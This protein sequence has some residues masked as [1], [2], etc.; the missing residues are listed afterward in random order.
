MKKTVSLL[1]ALILLSF[2][3]VPAS[4]EETE[5]PMPEGYT[6]EREDNMYLG[7]GVTQI[8][9]TGP[10]GEE[11]KAYYQSGELKTLTVSKADGSGKVLSAVFNPK[12]K[13]TRAT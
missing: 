8:E 1:L 4:A 9:E 6:P 10:D 13:I 11:Y 3:A 12:G 2:L 5:V 7:L